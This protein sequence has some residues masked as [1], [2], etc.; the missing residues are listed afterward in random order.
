M[1][2]P[3]TP[4]LTTRWGLPLAKSRNALAT[5]TGSPSPS[6]GTNAMAVGPSADLRSPVPGPERQSARASSCRSCSD[7][8]RSQRT[9]QGLHV[10]DVDAAILGEQRRLGSAEVLAHLVDHR[11]L[12]WSRVRPSHSSRL[13]A[14]SCPSGTGRPGPEATQGA[15]V[16]RTPRGGLEVSASSGGPGGEF[17]PLRRNRAPEVFGEQRSVQLWSVERTGE[18]ARPPRRTTMGLGPKR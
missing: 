16:Q 4:P 7:R 5:V 6:A 14:R 10:V 13:G 11:D 12:L 2:P 17:G 1:L 8:P 9:A 3:S 18:V 15:R